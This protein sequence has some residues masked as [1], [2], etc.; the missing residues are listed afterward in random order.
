GQGVRSAAVGLVL[1]ACEHAPSALD[2]HGPQA[3]QLAWLGWFMFA[4]A[5]A[6]FVLVMALLLYGLFRRRRTLAQPAAAGGGDTGA[7]WVVI[8][9]IAMPVVVLV[10]VLG[11]I[12]R[13]M[14]ALS[15]PSTPA[16]LTVEVIGYQYWWE[17]RYPQHGIVTANEIQIPVGQTVEFKLTSVDVIHSFWVPQLQGKMDLI[18]GKTNTVWLQADEPGVYRGQC[19]EFCGLQHAQMALLVIAQPPE[20]FAAWAD[21]QRRPA[22][23]STDSL[24]QRGAQVFA[25][26]GCI[27]CH[28]IRTGAGRVGGQLGPDLTHLASRRTIGAGTLDNNRGNLGGWVSNAQALKPGNKMP[29]QPMDGESLQALLAYL[30]SLE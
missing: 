16:N 22:V 19:A 17:V 6:I 21:A 20:Q 4:V 7:R 8:G 5:T 29:P 12:I 13:A 11:L 23:Q 18:P 3:A 28:A 26:E 24:V 1:V 30:E 15:A 14:P 27:T 10:V 2:P 9:G 25:R